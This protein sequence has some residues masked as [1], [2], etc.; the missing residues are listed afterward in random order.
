MDVH[1]YRF[2]PG[3]VSDAA[4]DALVAA[5]CEHA[6]RLP[7]SRR[8]GLRNLL[9]AVPAVA[10]FAR[11]PVIRSLIEPILGADACAVRGLFFDKPRSANWR[12]PWHRDRVIAV[13]ER[14][15][16]PGY[17]AW[18]TKDGVVHVE[19]P[20]ALLDGMLALRLHLDAVDADNGPLTV[21]PG[22]H[23]D[24]DVSDD[25]AIE[26]ARAI[27]ITGERGSVL[28]M[29]PLLAHA[30]QPAKHPDHRRV[31]HLEFAACGL[32]GGIEWYERR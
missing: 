31:L 21:I 8:G 32:P 28:L 27:A 30:S 10:R 24:V 6:A 15:E 29:R 9:S 7:S 13:R 26:E 12:V 23:R 25:A 2:L 16:V 3:S 20:R 19:P 1:G 11:S 4:C 18:S 5:L 17:G 14:R 22:S